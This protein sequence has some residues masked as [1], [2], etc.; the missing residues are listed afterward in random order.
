MLD[1]PV[2]NEPGV[3]RAYT[4]HAR[5][6]WHRLL[7]RHEAVVLVVL[8]V[9]WMYA[10]AGIAGF[11]RPITLTFLLLDVAPILLMVLPMT[12]VIISGEIDLSVASVF[13]LA[14]VVLG[15]MV[16]AGVP[17]ALAVL[18]AG[19]VGVVA[20]L[21]NGFLVTVLGLPSLAVTI[22]TLALFRGLAVGLLGTKAVTEFPPGW[23]SSAQSTIGDSAVPV[24]VVPIAVLAIAIGVLLH[25]TPFGR[26]V[27]AVGLSDEAAIFSGV[28][29]K[30]T[31]LVV[32]ALS[33]LCAAL[34]GVFYTLRF[35]NAIGSNGVGLELGVIAAVVLGGTSIF[36][37]RGSVA[38]SVLGALLIAVLASAL[39]LAKVPANAIDIITGAIL[40]LSIAVTMAI[41]FFAQRFTRERRAG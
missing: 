18:T 21:V 23:T 15:V 33:G 10:N 27:Y 13:G 9:V 38:G 8:V 34:A 41:P 29:V 28:L 36:G 7:V 11:G 1:T 40:V 2:T 20:G 12:L 3:T 4:V 14:S 17:I 32:F 30:R 35:G 19:L 39:R 5:G 24:I 37:G 22:G 16:K 25:L 6:L 26:G 31:K